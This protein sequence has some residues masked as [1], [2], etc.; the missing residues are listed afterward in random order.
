MGSS[1]HLRSRSTETARLTEF[2][3]RFAARH[4]L[5]EPER[6]RLLVILDELFTNVV[7]HGNKE[8]GAKGGVEISLAF[9]ANRLTIEF[10]D[11][12][13]P[14]DPLTAPVP[15]IEGPAEGRPVGGVGLLIVRSLVDEFGYTREGGRNRLVLRRIV[16]Q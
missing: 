1:L 5:P 12:G 7:D 13:L 14:F 3:S 9:E 11:D 16:R 6:A 8:P 4:G 10:V 15:E 2:A